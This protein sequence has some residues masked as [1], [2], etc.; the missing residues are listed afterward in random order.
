[1]RLKEASEALEKEYEKHIAMGEVAYSQQQYGDAMTHFIVASYFDKDA[2]E[3]SYYID[4]I[5]AESGLNIHYMNHEISLEKSAPG[6]RVI[7]KEGIEFA[8]AESRRSGDVVTCDFKLVNT[9]DKDA[10]FSFK[11]E[12]A[13]VSQGGEKSNIQKVWISNELKH[14]GS[15]IILSSN[16]VRTIKAR[17]I[18]PSKEQAMSLQSLK[19]VGYCNGS[20]ISI[21]YPDVLLHGRNES[22]IKKEHSDLALVLLGREREGNMLIFNMMA[23]NMK[24]NSPVTIT[25]LGNSRYENQSGLD[26]KPIKQKLRG[27]LEHPGSHMKLA[28]EQSLKF[29]MVFEKDRRN[30]VSFG[31]GKRLIIRTKMF[32][33]E[34][35]FEFALD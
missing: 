26:L 34:H 13:I 21:S 1:M 10:V 16:E 29:A 14:P 23:T 28:P 22:K 33:S 3:P 19:V 17:F 11:G 24:K 31:K 4:K 18:L 27:K 15:K 20:E 35:F 7:R 5:R 9:N 25:G 6:A 8:L 30:D 12:T 2:N 32:D